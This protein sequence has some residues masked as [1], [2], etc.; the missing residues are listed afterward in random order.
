M[1]RDARLAIPHAPGIYRML[2][3]SGDVLYIGKASSLHHRVNSHFRHQHGLAE[4]TLEM[5]SQ[6]RAISF[7][8]TPSVLEAALLEADEIKAHRPPYNV[9]LTVDD[10]AVWFTRRD[11]TGRSRH[12]SSR[13]R[14]G[15]FPSAEILDQFAALA[16]VNRTALGRGRWMPDAAVFAAGFARLCAAH[17]E[18]SRDELSMAERLLRAG[19]RLWQEGRRG[20]DG[21]GTEAA[22]VRV[23]PWTPESVQPA[24]EQLVVRAAL[25]RR[26][27]AW[28]TRL[29]D[30]TVVWSEP[31]EDAARLL[32]ID[33]GEIVCRGAASARMTPP[34][35]VGCLRPIGA[36]HRAFTVARFDRVRVLTTE[37]KRLVAAG[38][39]VAVRFDVAPA[40]AGTRLAAALSWV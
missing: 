6:A 18:L 24:L 37:L 8:I 20:R 27:A 10:R 3:T 21:D 38:A 9:A 7:E 22:D 16:Q 5:L 13:C 34:I 40:L 1:P 14:V 12:A 25:A 26:R 33:A 11:L 31:G 15:P 32:T 17:A 23:T 30:A 29:I 19:T 2:R 39:P 4:R 36:R 35:P 28:F